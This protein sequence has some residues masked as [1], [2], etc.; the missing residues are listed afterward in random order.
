MLRAA[1]RQFALFSILKYRDFRYYWVGLQMQ[2]T[3]LQLMWFTIGWVAFELTGS[4]GAV[5][6][7]SIFLFIPPVTVGLYGGVLADRLDQRRVIM[8]AQLLAMVAMAGVAALTIADRV[9]LW[10][11]MVTA[12]LM[13]TVPSFDQPSRQS[14]FPHLLPDRSLLSRA[15]P[16]NA[17]TWQIGRPIAPLFGGFIIGIIG[18]DTVPDA[19][20]AFALCA[21]G[22]FAASLLI[23]RVRPVARVE[24]PPRSVLHDLGEGIRAIG[25]HRV[26]RILIPTLF[27]TSVFGLGFQFVLPAFAGDVL[28]VSS[29]GLSVLWA[30]G[31]VGSFIGVLTTPAVVRRYRTGYAVLAW[32]L[33]FGVSLVAF[34]LT[35]QLWSA[36]LL[37]VAVGLA[38]LAYMICS[39][40]AV[41]TLVPDALRGRVMSVYG[42]AWTF[43][44]LGGALLNFIAEGTGTPIALALG[45]GIVM[46]VMVLVGLF[47][48]SLRELDISEPRKHEVEATA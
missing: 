32:G 38:S 14:L 10:H 27:V 12:L 16:L 23:L 39:E 15:V 9:V 6:S 2:V 30:S 7:V 8:A 33:L 4:P 25:Q 36:A 34:A 46:G 45:G 31:G 13:G 37:Q 19:G 1:V 5:G 24:R 42:L 18:S 3:A 44:T 17:M 41:Q 40:V 28:D 43:P 11:L 35:R 21:A 22:F 20:G 29:R 47:S 48:R 26:F